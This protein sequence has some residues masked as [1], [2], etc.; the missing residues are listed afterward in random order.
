MKNKL[1][2]VIILGLMIILNPPLNA[3]SNFTPGE[4]N[5]GIEQGEQ[6]SLIR[7]DGSGTASTQNDLGGFPIV[8]DRCMVK[9]HPFLFLE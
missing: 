7:S 8:I 2:I 9:V 5:F 6:S 1:M 3:K 4:A